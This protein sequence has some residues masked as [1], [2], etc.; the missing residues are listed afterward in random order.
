MVAELDVF[1]VIELLVDTRKSQPAV[2]HRNESSIAE[3]LGDFYALVEQGES[4][5]RLESS[6]NRIRQTGQLSLR[7]LRYLTIE[8]IQHI[9]GSNCE[10][11]NGLTRL[12][13]ATRPGLPGSIAVIG[14]IWRTTFDDLEAL[15]SPDFAVE[16]FNA[17]LIH[18]KFGSLIA[19]NDSTNSSAGRRLL[20][21]SARAEGDI[22]GWPNY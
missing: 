19:A 16:Q 14:T 9:L 7:N 6:F 13:G 5:S 8:W 15:H 12:L 10:I 3:L 21:L 22:G 17:Q 4:R 1:E 18:E 2:R 11:K 20:V